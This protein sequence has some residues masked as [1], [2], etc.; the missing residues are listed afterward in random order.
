VRLPRG[1][2]RFLGFVSVVA[3][4]LIFGGLLGVVHTGSKMGS[5]ATT[6]AVS[7]TSATDGFMLKRAATGGLTMELFDE[8]LD[9][10]LKYF[11]DFLLQLLL[12]FLLLLLLLL[13]SHPHL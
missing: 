9:E 6:G 7:C 1:F 8:L 12:L 5:T 10:L 13:L 4:L 11:E 3:A 2:V